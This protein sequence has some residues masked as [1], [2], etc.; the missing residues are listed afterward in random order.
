VKG[1]PISI[2]TQELERPMAKGDI[3]EITI[4]Y[5]L[6]DAFI[7]TKEALFTAIRRPTG[8][9]RL[10]IIFPK[11]RQPVHYIAENIILE[12]MELLNV[13]REPKIWL[14]DMPDGRQELLSE[15]HNPMLGSR[16][17]IEWTW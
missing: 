16:F 2:F 5:E 4:T 13:I 6:E 10:V 12:G 11:D 14:T 1:Q 8:I 17:I 9:A 3:L 7:S 15:I